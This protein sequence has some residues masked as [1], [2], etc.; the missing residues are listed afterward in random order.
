MRLHFIAIL[1]L[2]YLSACSNFEQVESK[3]ENGKLIELYQ[4]NKT[5]KKKEG[6]YSAFY[7]SGQ[8]LEESTYLNDSLIGERKLYYEN[9][10]LESITTHANGMFEGNY[11]KF[12][13]QGALTNEGKYVNN[14]MAGIWKKWYDTG[15]LME[16]VLFQANLENGPFKEYHKNGK[17]KTE[18][19]YLNGDNEQGELKIYDENGELVKRMYCEYGNCAEA[20]SKEKGEM[21]LDTARLKALAA[22]KKQTETME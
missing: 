18:G 6:P 11:Q 7:P 22:L 15:E 12:N 19:T 17:I 8:K 9:G 16:E 10:K 21:Q 3:D 5:T 1:F 14:E 4:V 2:L 13:E 20:W